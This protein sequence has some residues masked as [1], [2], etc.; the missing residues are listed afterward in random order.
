MAGYPG[1]ADADETAAVIGLQCL[2]RRAGIA[3]NTHRA[4]FRKRIAGDAGHC[5]RDHTRRC[6]YT[7]EGLALNCFQVRRQ[8]KG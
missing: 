2:G 7:G 1:V 8:E 5:L 4:A 6:F 3:V